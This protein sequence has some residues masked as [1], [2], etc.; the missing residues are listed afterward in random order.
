MFEEGRSARDAGE[1]TAALTIEL[2]L[3]DPLLWL[4]PS[5]LVSFLTDFAH[6]LPTFAKK[7]QAENEESGRSI[8]KPGSFQSTRQH[9]PAASRPQQAP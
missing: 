8:F 1:A 5:V 3:L 6:H 9:E 7:N 2:S 4:K